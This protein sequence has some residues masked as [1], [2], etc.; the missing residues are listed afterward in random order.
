MSLYNFL[1]DHVARPTSAE[2][3]E[4]KNLRYTCSCGLWACMKCGMDVAGSGCSPVNITRLLCQTH[5]KFGLNYLEFFA[6]VAEL[7]SQCFDSWGCLG[8]SVPCDYDHLMKVAYTSTLI[9]ACKILI[10]CAHAFQQTLRKIA[11]VDM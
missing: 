5:I 1:D 8:C 9:V 6:H 11:S 7:W 4:V 10:V 3:F 2:S